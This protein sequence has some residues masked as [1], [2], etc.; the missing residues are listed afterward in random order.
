[1]P[2]KKADKLQE[3]LIAGL[4]PHL[5]E[6]SVVWFGKNTKAI[7]HARTLNPFWRTHTTLI[8]KNTPLKISEF[9]RTINDLGYEKVHML[10][11]PGECTVMGGEVRIFP[12]NTKTPYRIDF[13][14]NTVEEIEAIPPPVPVAELDASQK[15]L[16]E[17]CS[18]GSLR[19]GDFVVHVDHGVGIF[20]GIIQRDSKPVAPIPPP[21]NTKKSAVPI[22]PSVTPEI[23]A[24]NAHASYL[25][26]EYARPKGANAPPDILLV[27]EDMIKKITPY[28]GFRTP[29][30]HRLGGSTWY[31]TK[32][33]VREDIIAFARDL[34]T[35]YATRE[36]AERTPALATPLM[37]AE[38]AA[39]FEHIE[40]PDQIRAIESILSEMAS[41]HPMDHLLLADVGFGKTEVALRAAFR[42]VL[43]KRQVAIIAPTTILA[44]QHFET[45]SGRFAE[46]PVCVERLS[47]VEGK[48][49]QGDIVR[50]LQAG[51]VDIVIGTHRLLSKDIEFRQLGLLIIDEEQRFGVKQK[52]QLKNKREGTDVLSL[53]ATPIP[54]TLHFALSSL[55]TMSSIHTPPPD[56]IAPKTFILPFGKR[57]VAQALEAELERGGQVYFL[58]NRIRTLSPTKEFLQKLIPRARI[59]TIHGRM[60]EDDIISTIH[61]FRDH[62]TDILLATTIIENGIDISNANTLIVEDASRIGLSQAHQLR[63]RIGRSSVQS[64]AYFLYQAKHLKEKA[65]MRLDALFRTQYLGAGQDIAMRDLDIRGAGNILGRNQSGHV[66]QIGMNLYC[67]M[68]A[69][70][71]EELQHKKTS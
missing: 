43:N 57:T 64:Y 40:T 20:K 1:M 8:T 67:Q 68:L 27:P 19:P 55:R 21:E 11:Y 42:S 61:D 71:V 12:I 6:K 32:K 5:L 37:E 39:G 28:V 2:P 50:R 35:L 18:L 15:K 48:K 3:L 66:N 14:G 47:R 31:S 51:T 13:L 69:E 22:N 62:K 7:R 34:L 4:H 23:P 60:K 49:E 41:P 53:S 26:I 10:T 52:E 36:L 38:L 63:G 45:F 70:A 58:S 17:K 33:K 30:I 29:A 56:R 9:L 54:R 59:G 16:L 25:Q 44:E 65:S 24:N 46:F